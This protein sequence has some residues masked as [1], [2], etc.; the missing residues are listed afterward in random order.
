MHCK[1]TTPLWW[2]V[3]ASLLLS[4]QSWN[5]VHCETL[6]GDGHKQHPTSQPSPCQGGRGFSCPI[7][8]FHQGGIPS[9][10]ISFLGV[11]CPHG[12][13]KLV[14]HSEWSRVAA[15]CFWPG[16]SQAFADH[17]DSEP[18]PRG[19]AYSPYQRSQAPVQ[20][21]G[22][23]AEVVHHSPA[24]RCWMAPTLRGTVLC[25]SQYCSMPGCQGGQRR[26][27]EVLKAVF[28][29][30]PVVLFWCLICGWMS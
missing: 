26:Q 14:N 29:H 8:L 13:W 15:S 24:A 25:P 9:F 20:A 4:V 28:L 30:I 7:L 12:I 11:Q 3:A 5:L 17:P 21:G 22:T 2:G 23:T 6:W 10:L 27:R 18:R 1:E 19:A 16:S